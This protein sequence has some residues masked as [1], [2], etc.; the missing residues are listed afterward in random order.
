MTLLITDITNKK[1]SDRV[2]K[3]IEPELKINDNKLIRNL[4]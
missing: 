2:F 1:F 4:V 3:D